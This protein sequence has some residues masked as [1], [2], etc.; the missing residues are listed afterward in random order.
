M[1]SATIKTPSLF[2]S[3][4]APFQS[5]TTSQILNNNLDIIERQRGILDSESKA[6]PEAKKFARDII[7]EAVHENKLAL[8]LD[9]KR[10][11]VYED[12]EK[13]RL[14]EI[15]SNNVDLRRKATAIAQDETLD[16][17][18]KREMINDLQTKLNNNTAEKQAIIDKYPEDVVL[19]KARNC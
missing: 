11:D 14:I 10:V 3:A 17:S 12:A 1:I 13:S 5:K 2:R 4:V 18:Q 8:E 15:E 9:I 16:D 7:E 6:S 19:N